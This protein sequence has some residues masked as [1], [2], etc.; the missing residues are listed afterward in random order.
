MMSLWHTR[1]TWQGFCLFSSY[2]RTIYIQMLPMKSAQMMK[3][4]RI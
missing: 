2:L 4:V 1:K 3:V